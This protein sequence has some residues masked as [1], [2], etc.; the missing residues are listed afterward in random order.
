MPA[1][2]RREQCC[3]LLFLCFV[4]T[5]LAQPFLPTQLCGNASGATLGCSVPQMRLNRLQAAAASMTGRVKPDVKYRNCNYGNYTEI[6]GCRNLRLVQNARNV[7]WHPR[8]RPRVCSLG[9][10][11]TPLGPPGVCHTY[12][13]GGCPLSTHRRVFPG[14][15]SSPRGG[16]TIALQWS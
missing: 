13:G 8:L 5:R 7:Y 11:G 16:N 2:R 10:E 15:G 1:P 6:T 12:Q 3:R 9:T 4:H 14:L